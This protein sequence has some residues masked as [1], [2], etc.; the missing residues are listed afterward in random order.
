MGCFCREHLISSSFSLFPGHQGT[1]LPG[2]LVPIARLHPQRC[3][4]VRDEMEHLGRGG[5]QPPAGRG[6]QDRCMYL[7]RTLTLPAQ[8]PPACEAWSGALICGC[9]HLRLPNTHFVSTASSSALESPPSPCHLS[10]R[11]CGRKC[12]RTG[13]A[14]PSWDTANSYSD[15]G[16]HLKEPKRN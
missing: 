6:A 14:P 13:A 7:L 4:N 10:T 5:T 3:G 2:P 1:G 16:S 11:W 8:D 15:V 9:H 12:K